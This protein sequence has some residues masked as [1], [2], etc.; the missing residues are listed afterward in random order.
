M[1]RMLCAAAVLL[2]TFSA[3]HAQAPFKIV[4][5]PKL[6]AKDAL[7]RM[8]LTM[9][10]NTRVT[11]DGN[12]DGLASVQVIPGKPSQL[13]VQ[14]FKGAVFLFDADN[15]DLIWKTNVGVPYWT[16]Q[17]AGFNSHSIFV[18]RRSVLHTLNRADGSQ[19]V[20]TYDPALKS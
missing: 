3:A 15:G 18:T 2:T 9:A 12:R 14:T 1:K 16:P 5:R 11:V 20:Y 10:W 7:E 8:N 19:R 6:P 13:V 17:A 4:T